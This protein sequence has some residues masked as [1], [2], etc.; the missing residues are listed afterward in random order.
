MGEI[1][2]L[3]GFR[4]ISGHPRGQLRSVHLRGSDLQSIQ[5]PQALAING[6]LL[7]DLTRAQNQNCSVNEAKNQL[8]L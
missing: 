4:G 1:V 5:K 6:L 7:T 2:S 3:E 8:S